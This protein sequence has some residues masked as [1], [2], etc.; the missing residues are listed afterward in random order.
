M[1]T[2]IEKLASLTDAELRDLFVAES[3]ALDAR[4]AAGLKWEQGVFDRYDRIEHERRT[5]DAT[6]LGF[7]D[8][9]TYF[10]WM[11]LENARQVVLSERALA[12]TASVD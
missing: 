10:A 8:L 5:R 1:N 2:M 7:R 9:D 4:T 12:E 3:A 11:K 6:R